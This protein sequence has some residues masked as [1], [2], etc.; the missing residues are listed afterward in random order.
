MNHIKENGSSSSFVRAVSGYTPNSGDLVS[1]GSTSIGD[2]GDHGYTPSSGYA[3]SGKIMLSAVIILFTVVILFIC[4]H[5]YA[6][7]YILRARR[8]HRERRIRRRG[9]IVFSFDSAA[10]SANTVFAPSRGLDESVLKS[11]PTFVYSSATDGGGD[12]VLECAVCLSEFEEDEKG[13]LLPQCNHSFHIDCI[14]MWFHSHST[15]PLCRTPVNMKIPAPEVAIKVDEPESGSSSGLCPSCCFD[16][17]CS[18]SSSSQTSSSS[19]TRR[20]ESEAVNVSIEVPRRFENLRG[21]Q[22]EEEPG[23]GSSGGQGLKSPGGQQGLKSPGGRILSLKRILSREW[24]SM[25]NRA[26][27]EIDLE[28]GE[29]QRVQAQPNR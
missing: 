13:R 8:R 6:R 14:D 12:E 3:L 2:Q 18:S 1:Y 15:C 16:V 20:K 4:L 21:F 9:H 22:E 23:L 7:W 27:T 24:T 5:I 10:A 17:G 19:D 29:E 11:L 25:S 28:S 26:A